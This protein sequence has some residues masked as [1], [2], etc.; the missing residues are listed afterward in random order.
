MASLLVHETDPG[1]HLQDAYAL[2]N[3]AIPM[4]RR[5]V[6]Y[7][8]YFAAPVH[9]PFYTTY[10]EVHVRVIVHTLGSCSV[11]RGCNACA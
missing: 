7:S 8:K 4:F 10:S 1:H 5:A 3:P 9:F 6:D 2:T 11:K